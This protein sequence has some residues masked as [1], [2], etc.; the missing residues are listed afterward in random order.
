MEGKRRA[1]VVVGAGREREAR[2]GTAKEA[3]AGTGVVNEREAEAVTG[4]A[5]G[6]ERG[7]AAVPGAGSVQVASEQPCMYTFFQ[8][9]HTFVCCA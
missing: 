9:V 8:L 4:D 3:R 6:A 1:E 7:N 2:A 5:V